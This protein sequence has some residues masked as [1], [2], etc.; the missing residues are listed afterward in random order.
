[1]SRLS[2][3]GATLMEAMVVV[4]IVGVV[5][6]GFGI[7]LQSNAR[8]PS[9]VDKR[10]TIHTFLVEKM[11]DIA[12]MSFD[13]VSANSGLSD[14]VAVAGQTLNR[15]VTVAPIDAD[16]NGAPDSDFI[17]V[18]VTINDQFLKTRMAKP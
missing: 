12:S 10:L 8:I 6:L 3:R 5:A 7:S 1:M 9:A 4:V 17:E 18:T 15:T 11:E 14:T 2:K 16:G 13:T